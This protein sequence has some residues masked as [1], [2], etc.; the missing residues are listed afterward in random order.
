MDYTVYMVFR[1]PTPEKNS[2]TFSVEQFWEFSCFF[3]LTSDMNMLDPHNKI[4][5]HL[6]FDEES[7]GSDRILIGPHF[8]PKKGHFTPKNDPKHSFDLTFAL[9]MLSFR[10]KILQGVISNVEHDSDNQNRPIPLTGL[11]LGWVKIKNVGV[12]LTFD[13]NMIA[14]S[15]KILYGFVWSVEHDSDNKNYPM[16]HTGLSLGQASSCK[17]VF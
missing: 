5:S 8:D 2:S 3:D 17:I 1:R 12:L 16:P 11:S 13:P 7:I 9:I 10:N 14:Y 6:F 15:N 4:L